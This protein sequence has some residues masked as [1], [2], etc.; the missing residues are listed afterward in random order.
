M[1]HPANTAERLAFGRLL[2]PVA[3]DTPVHVA[4]RPT[5]A[6]IG[7]ILIGAIFMV[8]GIAKLTDTAGTAGYMDAAGIPYAPQLAVIAGIAEIVGAL[9]LI[10]GFLTRIGALGLIV[11]MIPT[12]LLFHAFWT[13]DGPEQKMQMVDFMKNLAIIG[14]LAMI[15]AFGPSRY[16]IDHKIRAPLQP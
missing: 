10:F 8:S 14:G 5:T 3:D 7:R 9:S 1:I 13:F 2:D 16:S 11:F 12:T 6:L 15:F 4:Q